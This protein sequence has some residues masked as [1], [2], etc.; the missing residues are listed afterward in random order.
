VGADALAI[1]TAH[2][3]YRKLDLRALGRRMRR[4]VLVDGRNLFRGPEVLKAGFEY[5]GIGKG[6]Y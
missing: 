3:A 4:K 6:E 2:S 1:V 5:R